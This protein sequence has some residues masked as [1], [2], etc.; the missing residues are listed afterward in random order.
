MERADDSAP[1]PE[2]PDDTTPFAVASVPLRPE[3]LTE[4]RLGR[5]SILLEVTPDLPAAKTLHIERVAYYDF[6]ADNPF[7]IFE[8][9]SLERRR[10]VLA[11]FSS[12]T[13]TYH[14]A[15]QRFA[16]RRR[17]LQHDLALVVARGLVEV[18][19]VGRHVAFALTPAGIEL[20]AGLHGFY[21]SAYRVSADLVVRHLNRLSDRRLNEK[22]RQWLSAQ[23]FL[24]DLYDAEEV[25]L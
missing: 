1:G 5:L 2:R 3:D 16:N 19:P 25:A 8:S 24:V 13:L 21:A 17:R 7:L 20:A 9:G 15:A 18:A 4:F 23:E 22:A 6:F 11:G 12:R 10:L 14:S